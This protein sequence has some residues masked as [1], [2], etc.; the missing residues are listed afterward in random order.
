MG[1]F[2]I[3]AMVGALGYLLDGRDGALLGINLVFGLFVLFCATAVLFPK[4][5]ATAEN[6]PN[7]A[8]A[9]GMLWLIIYGGCMVFIAVLR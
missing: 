5:I 1:G 7:Q 8:W 6:P 2:L 4:Q 9:T 3:A